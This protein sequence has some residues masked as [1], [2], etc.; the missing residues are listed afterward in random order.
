MLA[1]L[2]GQLATDHRFVTHNQ[3]IYSINKSK[4]LWSYHVDS[5]TFAVITEVSENIDY[6][7]DINDREFILPLTIAAKKEMIEVSLRE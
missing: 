2:R 7:T 6:L 1:P 5:D 4:R 3:Q